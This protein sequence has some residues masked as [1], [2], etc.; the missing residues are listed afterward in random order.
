MVPICAGVPS[1]GNRVAFIDA[2][3]IHG[4]RRLGHFGDNQP[5]LDIKT[6]TPACARRAANNF[7]TIAAPAF[8]TQYS[9]IDRGRG[10][11]RR[12]DHDQAVVQ[13][14]QAGAGEQA[15]G[16]MPDRGRT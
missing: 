6:C 11:V 12:R 8:D 14:W 10:G 15:S 9:T 5:R 1:S 2:L 3:L 13:F 16:K 7:A 4:Q